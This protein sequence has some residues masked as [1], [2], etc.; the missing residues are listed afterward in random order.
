MTAVPQPV[1]SMR[2][3]HRLGCGCRSMNA[4][5][6]LVSSSV[7]ERVQARWMSRT[8]DDDVVSRAKLGDAD[9]WRSLYQANATRLKVWLDAAPIEDA[10][11]DSEDIAAT[12]WMTAS[13]KIDGFTGSA[14]DFAG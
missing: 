7:D 14:D 5:L 13:R 6:L 2:G 9:A 4:C 12:A 1:E 11:A 10:A 8:R 3:A